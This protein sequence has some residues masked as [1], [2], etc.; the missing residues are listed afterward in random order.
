MTE[1]APAEAERQLIAAVER[2]GE[3]LSAVAA[4]AGADQSR[5]AAAAALAR[6]VRLLAFT[7]T[8]AASV[9]VPHERLAECVGGDAALVEEVLDQGPNLVVIER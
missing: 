9:G 4:A 6:R 8:R 5:H 1:L 3:V 2:H 7:L